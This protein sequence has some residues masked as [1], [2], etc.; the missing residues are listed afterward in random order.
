MATNSKRGL[1]YKQQ[2]F[3]DEYLISGN[4]T[5]AARK[6]GYKGNDNTL[7]SMGKENLRKPQILAVIES[8]LESSKITADETLQG[9]SDMAT[10]DISDF[11]RVSGGLP[12]VDFDKAEK[13]G[14]LHLIKKLTMSDGKI[15][16]ELYSKQRALETMAKHYGLLNTKIEID[17]N[18]MIAVVAAIETLGQ[19]PSDVFNRIIQRAA[20]SVDADS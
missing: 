5:D 8:H 13:A 20:Q 16:F 4:A 14:K 17:I 1:T 7:A 15:S 18:M 11:V 2:L 10:S 19:S 3:V 9:L 6:A 12:I